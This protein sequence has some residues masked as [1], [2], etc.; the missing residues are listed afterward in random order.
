[1]PGNLNCPTIWIFEGV[2]EFFKV[3]IGDQKLI[4]VAWQG[5]QRPTPDLDITLQMLL[6]HLWVT[7]QSIYFC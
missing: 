4:L 6:Y 2:E 7:L 1:M 5:K 3:Q